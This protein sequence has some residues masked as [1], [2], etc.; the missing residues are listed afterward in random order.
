MNKDELNDRI[1]NYSYPLNSLG[2]FEIICESL[3]F[4]IYD[5]FGKNM[6]LS[7]LYQIGMSPGEIIANRIKQKYNK[8]LDWM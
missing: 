6:L 1:R 7:M 2:G 8:D 5:I 3:V 4:K